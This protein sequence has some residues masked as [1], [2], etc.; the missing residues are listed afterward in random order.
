MGKSSS[1]QATGSRS[2]LR[3][4]RTSSSYFRGS[5]IPDERS[6]LADQLKR[7]AADGFVAPSLA[8]GVQ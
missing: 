7:V 4:I 5:S 2:I 8:R 1:Y 3:A 6:L